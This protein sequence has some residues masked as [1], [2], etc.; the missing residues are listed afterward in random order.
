VITLN[1]RSNLRRAAAPQVYGDPYIC[2]EVISL[3]TPRVESLLEHSLEARDNPARMR[4][5]MVSCD[6][7]YREQ[8]KST[9]RRR[10]WG[11]TGLDY[12]DEMETAGVEA[13]DRDCERWV[14]AFV[15][16]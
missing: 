4:W 11:I 13:A 10:V 15:R 14:E 9:F 16:E 12:F 1:E 3:P 7:K 2:S 6:P 8:E 5:D